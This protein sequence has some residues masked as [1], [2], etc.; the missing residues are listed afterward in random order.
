MVGEIDDTAAALLARLSP[1][2][3]VIQSSRLALDND[4]RAAL[5]DGADVFHLDTYADAPQ[6]AADDVLVSNMQDGPYGVRSA[7]LA[8][9]SNL[10]AENSFARTDLSIAQLVGIDVAVVRSQVLRLRDA[11][12]TVSSTP[13]VLVVMGGTDSYKLTP[14]VIRAL[15]R[16]PFR[17]DV[18]IVAV[19]GDGSASEAA[20][21]SLHNIEIVDFVED[22]PALARQHDLAISAAGTSV[23]DFACMG[24]PMALICV[25]DNQRGGYQA[26]TDAGFAVGL[27]LP[28]HHD[29]DDRVGDLARFLTDSEWFDHQGHLLREAVD[30]RGAWR[31]VSTW[32]QMLDAT[33][34]PVERERQAF[35]TRPA[36]IGDARLLFDWRNE[37]S[38]RSR[39]RTRE[40]LDWDL[41]RA[42]LENVIAD[43][44]RKLLIVELENE[45]VATVRWDLHAPV[46]W[47]V[48]VTIAPQHRRMGYG[49]DV[50]SV[51]EEALTLEP[52][53]R[54]V[55]DI[56]VDNYASRR[57]FNAAGYLP[58][59]PSDADG[60]ERRAK[61]QLPA[62]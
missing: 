30:G 24:L 37:E 22:L 3:E 32:E 26:V 56:H 52:P 41:H 59:A 8:I 33:T 4:V 54:M 15:G 27:G 48:S 14:R 19:G 13:R 11:E 6:V 5:A 47:E 9:D 39:S 23:W 40:A 61:W 44:Q 34:E 29:L 18:T 10:G 7:D 62:G 17:L 45:P 20:V 21:G 16:I 49:R 53:F 55:A 1:E 42:W 25:A 46:D 43:P 50:L 36:E 2:V 31:I 57:L 28:P 51:A 58:Q 35:A 38:T 60:F 12:K